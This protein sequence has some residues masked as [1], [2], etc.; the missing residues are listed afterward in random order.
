MEWPKLPTG[1]DKPSWGG[2]LGALM[3]LYVFW[4][5]YHKDADRVEWL[6][7]GLAFAVFVSL[8]ALGCIY[9]SRRRIVQA[10]C[11]AIAM[12]AIGFSAYRPSGIIYFIFVAAFAPLA[13]GGR[14]AAS[15]AIIGG[16]AVF[17]IAEWWLLRPFSWMPIIVAIEALVIGAAMTIVARQ[18]S[19]LRRT[20]K[21]AERVRIARDLHDILGHTLSL[22]TLK[23]ELASR[24]LDRDPSRARKEIEEV[25]RISRTGSRAQPSARTL[26]A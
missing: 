6:W 11:I 4:D 9:W 23:S 7:T 20:L 21:T 17:I 22:I 19:A 12:L 13:V 24:L 10:V 8:V 16:T 3:V 14:I 18:Q 15:A 25:E 5:P 1:A 2:M 26:P